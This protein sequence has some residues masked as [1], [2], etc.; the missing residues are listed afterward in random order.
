MTH[1]MVREEAENLA[2]MFADPDVIAKSIA[3][4]V[5]REAM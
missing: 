4:K 2:S 1:E 3:K 5:D